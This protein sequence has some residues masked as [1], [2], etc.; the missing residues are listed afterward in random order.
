MLR[1]LELVGFKTFAS[2]TRFEFRGDLTAIVGP[3]GS[4]KSN[5][6]DAVR[7]VLAEPA[8]RGLRVRKAEDLLFAGG[9]GR[10]PAGYAEATIILDNTARVV[11]LDFDEVAVTRRLYRSGESDYWLNGRRVRQRDVFD[12]LGRAGLFQSSYAVIGQG[13]IDAA[14]SLRPEERRELIEE[15]A[16]IRRHHAALEEARGRLAATRLNLQ[17]LDDLL[18]ELRPRVEKLAKFAAD[19]EEHRRLTAALADLLATAYA[20]RWRAAQQRY[21]RAAA[22]AA[23]RV[24]EHD[25][26]RAR[27][28]QT[29]DRLT[30]LRSE[31]N[32][33]RH[34]HDHLLNELRTAHAAADR[35]RHEAAFA[36]RE[37]DR[38]TDELTRLEADAEEAERRAAQEQAALDAAEQELTRLRAE[39]ERL[40]TASRP[41]AEAADAEQRA[42]RL[43]R[44]LE[45][46]RAEQ[47]ALE[48]E[49]RAALALRDRLAAD[50]AALDRLSESPALDPALDAEIERTSEQA[51]AL[52]G[53]IESLAAEREEARQWLTNAEEQLAAL[54]A[55]RAALLERL[56]D[57]DRRLQHLA[58]E[59]AA[60]E[61]YS[62]AVRAVLESAGWQFGAEKGRRSTATAARL[63]GIVGT[64]ADLIEVP[65]G[66]E[67]A[68]EAALGAR[69]Q[70]IVVESW[71]EAEEAIQ[72]LRAVG[73]GRATFLPLD[74]IQPGRRASWPAEP[75]VHGA[76][77]DLCR[78]DPRIRAIVDR[79]LG[80]VIIVDSLAVARRCLARNGRGHQFV[81]VRGETVG[82]W[83]AITGGSPP[84]RRE[85]RWRRRA[86]QA[87]IRA[88]REALA[89]QGETLHRQIERLA[90][91]AAGRRERERALAAE[92]E[93][94]EHARAETARQ[95][96]RLQARAEQRRVALEAAARRQEETAAR[97]AQLMTEIEALTARLAVIDQRCSEL[98]RERETIEREIAEAEA[99]VL[100]ARQR[101]A[102]DG[103]QLAALRAAERAGVD[104]V[105]RIG[106]GI[107][108]EREIAAAA[109]RRR[110]LLARQRETART[111][112]ERHEAVV[113]AALARAE[114]LQRE[115]EA[116]GHRRHALEQELDRLVEQEQ[117]ERAD[118]AA[119][120]ERLAEARREREAAADALDQLRR[121]MEAEGLDPQ[122]LPSPP[123]D[124]DLDEIERQITRL[125]AR[126]RT[127][128]SANYAL[129][130]EYE[131]ERARLDHGLAQ[132]AD[133]RAAEAN[134]AKTI[135]SLETLIAERF[136]QTV[137]A[138]NAE[139]RRYFQRLFGG[140]SAR[141]GVSESAGIEIEV[142]PP[143]KRA[144]SLALLSGGE[145]ALTAAALV[146]ALLRVNPI[147][148]CVLDEV[149]AALDESNV[150]RF[151]AALLELAATT[152]FVVITH[153]RVTI[154]AAAAVYGLT[155]GAD[156]ATKIVSLQLRET[157]SRAMP[158]GG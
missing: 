46:R 146:F 52:A 50:L 22:S 63:T 10:P 108:R 62:P 12:A 43:R 157:S 44:L 15:A 95:L 101:L 57:C 150:R 56:R 79:L 93:R 99:A 118:A 120:A 142:Q 94:L 61:E 42:V 138:V 111:D 102:R 123:P 30:A 80:N 55:E 2:R 83:G 104:T 54:R 134:L 128:P 106:A 133:L 67:L 58:Y 156:G 40:E 86:R 82:S 139:F 33:A 148:F 25:A 74:T 154:E 88:E 19:A 109:R 70:D 115:A 98:G 18:R 129:I 21:E 151:V 122:R 132:L 117:A 28:Q 65:A 85:G 64:V 91:E 8:G 141:L 75:G 36:A 89:Q 87:S 76:A 9:G 73:A 13:L 37:I 119:A 121:R 136:D 103:A 71:R 16:D 144:Q 96:A 78:H 140:G 26:L 39:I 110:D 152:Q 31:A 107:A 17:R 48:A 32:A 131:E 81:T 84:S 137:A 125:R 145:R 27:L 4:G 68:F 5:V 127:L 38:F 45:E 153:N 158:G 105:R 51:A 90:A 53:R 147:P 3:N 124:V 41:S 92:R 100:E 143:G 116:L 77:A 47:G 155:V 49:R 135:E 149:D 7:W 66:Y 113:A 11:P 112:V 130:A 20:I 34:R 126:L 72:F 14:L 6:A 59:E 60:G 97:R 23:E 29:A 1:A 35:A 114:M 24:G 69:S